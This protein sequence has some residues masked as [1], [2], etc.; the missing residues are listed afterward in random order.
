MTLA[1]FHLLL[2]ELRPNYNHT[3]G[4]GR[5]EPCPDCHLHNR[6]IVTLSELHALAAD[7][8]LWLEDVWLAR[9]DRQEH[10][11]AMSPLIKRAYELGLLPHIPE[12]RS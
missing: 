8:A 2:R 12:L 3:R 9:G 4:D 6:A 10:T 7:L 11:D 5:G 1:A